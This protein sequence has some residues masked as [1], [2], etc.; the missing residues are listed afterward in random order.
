MSECYQIWVT[1]FGQGPDVKLLRSCWSHDQKCVKMADFVNFWESHVNSFKNL[2]LQTHQSEFYQIRVTTLGQGSE[3]RQVLWSYFLVWLP[4]G[5]IKCLIL[6]VSCFLGKKKPRLFSL[7]GRIS[8]AT[9][10]LI[11]R[12][13]N[14]GSISVLR[15]QPSRCL[16][17]KLCCFDILSLEQVLFS[18]PCSKGSSKNSHWTSDS[19]FV[20]ILL[21]IVFKA[22]RGSV[23]SPPLLE[24]LLACQH[25]SFRFSRLFFFVC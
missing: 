23:L 18:Y 2:S 13:G 22:W 10:W 19:Q 7:W 11:L 20:V 14:I 17:T 9:N 16:R 25:S 12:V 5:G 8:S 15:L 6:V 24:L 1:T 21:G 4:E 3:K